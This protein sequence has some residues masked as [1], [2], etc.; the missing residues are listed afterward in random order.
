M[1]R[2]LFL[3]S[4][5]ACFDYA[6]TEIDI[7][8]SNQH[9]P[10][11]DSCRSRLECVGCEAVSKAARTIRLCCEVSSSQSYARSAAD[12]GQ[13]GTGCRYVSER[14][15]CLSHLRCANQ[16]ARTRLVGELYGRL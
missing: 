11:I 6:K 13:L 12:T 9:H 5:F 3:S 8:L 16:L 2:R 7:A 15:D 1:A 4:M 14:N 10:V